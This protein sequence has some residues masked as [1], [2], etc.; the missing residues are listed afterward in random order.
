MPPDER[1]PRFPS[2]YE[3]LNKLTT[4]VRMHRQKAVEELGATTYKIEQL[5]GDINAIAQKTRDRVGTLKAVA[6]VAI[7][8]SLIDLGL[9]IFWKR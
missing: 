8:L 1:E 3:Q 9:I 7:A 6:I 2:F 4:V 5:R